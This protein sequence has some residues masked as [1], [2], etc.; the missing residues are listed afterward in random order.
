[1]NAFC[2]KLGHLWHWFKTGE[3]SEY[4]QC[5]RCHVTRL[6]KEREAA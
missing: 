6:H 5:E 1:M 4:E 2:L 3:Q